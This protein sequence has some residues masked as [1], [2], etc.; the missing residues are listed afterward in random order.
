MVR[1][2]SSS[3]GTEAAPDEDPAMPTP[4]KKKW[5]DPFDQ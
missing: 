1:G 2:D 3:S 5:V 4:I